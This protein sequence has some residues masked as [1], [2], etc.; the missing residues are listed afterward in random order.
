MKK[1]CAVLQKFVGWIGII[2][3]ALMA[4]YALGMATPA[5][6][7]FSY[8]DTID[9]YD[10]IQPINNGILIFAICGLLVSGIYS[11]MRNSVRKIYYVS[12]YVWF[13][14]YISLAIA[15][16]IY[17]IQGVNYYQSQ[18]NVLPFDT[19]NTYWE[20]HYLTTRINRNTSVF[21]LGYTEAVLV[22]LSVIPAAAVIA[23][24]AVE[25][26]SV[27]KPQTK[28]SISKEETK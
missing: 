14:I 17:L 6:C 12:N 8:Q 27:K 7:L 2:V 15:A 10:A 22:L 1:C 3:F 18:Y 20:A 25:R 5:S 16:A 4:I 19:L 28:I 11:M 9:F 26:F 13:A 21:W 24:K 23:E